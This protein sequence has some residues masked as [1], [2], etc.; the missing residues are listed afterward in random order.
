V[1]ELSLVAV[2]KIERLCDRFQVE[3]QK[4][5]KE[6]EYRIAKR[7]QKRLEKEREVEKI[8]KR[9]L[10]YEDMD[11]ADLSFLSLHRDLKLDSPLKIK[12]QRYNEGLIQSFASQSSISKA[13]SHYYQSAHS[14]SFSVE[15]S[16]WPGSDS[17][18]SSSSDS[19]V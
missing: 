13:R 18:S 5:Q 19:E 1:D 15:E 4:L 9:S 7:E 8:T 11:I 12:V 3:N 16:K 2:V 10:P 14:R 17:S 6:L